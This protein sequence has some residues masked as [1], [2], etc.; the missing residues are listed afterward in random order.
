MVDVGGPVRCGCPV[1]EASRLNKPASRAPPCPSVLPP[2][3]VGSA[4]QT[5][6]SSGCCWYQAVETQGTAV[7][8]TGRPYGICF[9]TP[10]TRDHFKA[11]LMIKGGVVPSLERAQLQ[12]PSQ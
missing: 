5:N 6:R 10:A 3:T 8:I 9:K 4:S 7:Q 12:R 1:V 2:W 11:W